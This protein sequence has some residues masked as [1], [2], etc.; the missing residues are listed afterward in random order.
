MDRYHLAWLL[1]GKPK[2]AIRGRPMSREEEGAYVREVAGQKLA[3]LR[4]SLDA[5]ERQRMPFRGET[6]GV[7]GGQGMGAVPATDGDDS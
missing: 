5:V 3:P 7:A 1:V 6:G 4:A 2:D